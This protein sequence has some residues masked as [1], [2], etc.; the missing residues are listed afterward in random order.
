DMM[1]A[2]ET[3]DDK[4]A[5]L[6]ISFYPTQITQL[7]TDFQL[8]NH[9][10]ILVR[11]DQRDLIEITAKG[12]R[13]TLGG[14]I[15]L[16][17]ADRMALQAERAVAKTQWVA[18]IGL[19][20]AFYSR[21][22]EE[23]FLKICGLMVSVV[24]FWG[25]G[26]AMLA[27]SRRQTEAA[28]KALRAETGRL[29][30]SQRIAR[31]GSWE[32]DLLSDRHKWTDEVYR[33]LD[34]PVSK[35]RSPTLDSLKN[36]L[37]ERDRE[38]FLAALQR[39]LSGQRA[40]DEEVAIRRHGGAEGY[41]HI[42]AN[43]TFGANGK[44]LKL[45]GAIHDVTE[46]VQLDR[47]KAIFISAVNH[48]LRTPLTSIKGS[49]SL[50]DAG[51]MG[52]LPDKART[53]IQIAHRNVDRLIDLVGDIL[54]IEK[55]QSGEMAYRLEKVHLPSL[56]EEA[57]LVNEGYA[58]GFKTNLVIKGDVPDLDLLCDRGRILQVLTNLISNAIKFSPENSEVHVSAVREDRFIRLSVQDHGKGISENFRSRVFERFAQ[59]IPSGESGRVGT[60]LGLAICKSI[61][62][63]HGGTITFETWTG[64][65]T[66][67]HFAL[68]LYEEWVEALRA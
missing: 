44:P 39:A 10:V 4:K 53:L 5:L 63:G 40:L 65:G 17:A 33:I 35:D 55:L 59:E 54:N 7:I 45:A 14:T 57:V 9:R 47:A 38:P 18:L 37:Q 49:L 24:L 11:Q 46:R 13:D 34:V 41:L 32:W 68:P 30:N 42:R 52:R 2:W 60:G 50:M 3:T 58:T 51:A 43:I 6:F 67:F 1:E 8:P 23:V 26:I 62:E 36:R 21:K 12:A 25:L 48:E 27:G 28:F 56:L 31:I 15:R 19:E 20:T 29:Q 64:K 61:V 16:T 66:I 22:Q